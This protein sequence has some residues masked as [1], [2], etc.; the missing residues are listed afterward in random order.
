MVHSSPELYLDEIQHWFQ[1]VTG[2]RVC[3]STIWYYL[4]R[5]GFSHMKSSIRAYE[6]DEYARAEHIRFVAK[7]STEMFL[8][9]DESSKDSRTPQRH[10]GFYPRG[11]SNP[12]ILGNF[13]RRHKISI[14][15]GLDSEGIV[16]SF[17][18]DGSYNRELFLMAFQQ[19][20]LPHLGSFCHQEARSIIVMDNCSIHTNPELVDCI[21]NAGA[22]LLFLPPYSPDKNPI[23]HIFN[24]LKCW[25]RRNF[26]YA[27]QHPKSA[28]YDAFDDLPLQYARNC[29]ESCGY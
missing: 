13:V 1:D 12:A 3:S 9:V 25:L 10:Y 2:K 11:T 5:M 19:S 8:F 21:R 24:Y 22:I 28:V 23:E 29:I 18:V 26:A 20:L 6:R 16:G 7:F 14:M 4:Q 15:A 27:E 17:I